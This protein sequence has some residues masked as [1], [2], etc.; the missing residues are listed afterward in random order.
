M[1]LWVT[2]TVITERHNKCTIVAQWDPWRKY[3]WS[4]LKWLCQMCNTVVAF[5]LFFCQGTHHN[6]ESWRCDMTYLTIQTK[7]G[8][9]LCTRWQNCFWLCNIFFKTCPWLPH[10]RHICIASELW[11]VD[12]QQCLLSHH[13]C[14]NNRTTKIIC[15]ILAD[16]F[17]PLRQC[18]EE[19]ALA[20]HFLEQTWI[21]ANK[22]RWVEQY[23]RSL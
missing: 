3:N 8:L 19:I 20:W 5:I 15:L 10:V 6:R 18:S 17:L 23:F 7:V 1:D 16:F 11:H 21:L 4:R 9:V 13:F 22:T 2:V 14:E 12:T